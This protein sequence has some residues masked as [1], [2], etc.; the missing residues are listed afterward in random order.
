MRTQNSRAYDKDGNYN[1]QI[2]SV[3]LISYEKLEPLISSLV[4]DVFPRLLIL[5]F[6]YTT[7]GPHPGE[8][9]LYNTYQ[10][11]DKDHYNWHS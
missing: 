1:K 4:K 9:L 6:G 8:H 10:S 11:K 2:S 7:F 5:D 3:K